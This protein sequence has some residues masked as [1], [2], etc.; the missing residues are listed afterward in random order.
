MD[1]ET[2]ASEDYFTECVIM[3][4]VIILPTYNERANLDPL[5]KEIFQHVPDVHVHIIDD[6]SPDGTGALAD[7]LAAGDARISVAHRAGKL[8][9]GTA[10]LEGFRWALKEG[11]TFIMEMDADFSHDPAHLPALLKAGLTA[12]LVLGSRYVPG[13]GTENWGWWRRVL[14]RGGGVYAR[15]ILQVPYHDLT[16]GFKVFHRRVLEALPLEDIRSEGYCFQIEMTWRAH[17]QGFRIVELPIL[18]RERREGQSKISR[19]I[20]FEAMINVWRLR[21]E[22]LLAQGRAG[23]AHE[24]VGH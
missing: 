17:L 5:L 22:T 21:L 13:G 9:L 23:A 24:P 15:S 12:D 3:S 8:G 10:Y 19:R 2:S 1:K 7:Q 6:A 20:V 11:F 16:G 4:T 14:S 18:F